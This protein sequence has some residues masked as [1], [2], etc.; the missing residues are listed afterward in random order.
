MRKRARLGEGCNGVIQAQ[1]RQ[2][3]ISRF[4]AGFHHHPRHLNHTMGMTV[5]SAITPSPYQ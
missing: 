5:L 1:L 4:E 3:A 2:G